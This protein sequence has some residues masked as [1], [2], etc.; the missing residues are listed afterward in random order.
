[1]DDHASFCPDH[2]CE[3]HSQGD[4]LLECVQYAATLVAQRLSILERTLEAH[5][6]RVEAAAMTL[7]QT[8]RLPNARLIQSAVAVGSARLGLG[9]SAPD[10]IQDH[11]GGKQM[12]DA[13]A[14]TQKRPRSAE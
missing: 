13:V 5:A 1:M 4:A 9:T 10:V 7:S 2:C 6:Q 14:S 12:V 8:G 11:S 3:Y